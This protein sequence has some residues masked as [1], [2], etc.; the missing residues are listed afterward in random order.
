MVYYITG[1]NVFGQ[2]LCDDAVLSEFRTFTA[3][4]HDLGIGL[5]Q[6]NL[7]QI[8]WSYNIFESDSIFYI[9]GAWNGKEQQLV[10]IPL[11]EE[12]I[13]SYVE[14]S[15]VGN[16]YKILLVG[17]N[18]NTLWVI[19]LKTNEIKRIHFNIE[20]VLENIVKKPKIDT[21]I[22]KASVTN[23]SCIFLTSNGD[24]Y[25]GILPSCVDTRHCKGKIIDVK[26]GYE[27]FVLLTEK[28]R[29]YTWGNGRWVS[30]IMSLT[31]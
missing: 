22:T 3:T 21:T 18:V 16:D 12:C 15:V 4:Q 9:T 13:R 11:P 7:V 2:W 25:T 14:L 1:S 27:H 5:T 17:K 19:D 24:V 10:K 6:A 29:V 30:I 23:D 31:M 8:N 20:E 26:C 28:G